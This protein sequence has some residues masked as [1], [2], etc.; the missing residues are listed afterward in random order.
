MK[1]RRVLLLSLM[2]FALM[3]SLV[4]QNQIANP[5]FEDWTNGVPDDWSVDNLVNAAEE[6]TIVYAGS[7]SLGW[8]S[9]GT[10][11]RTMISA[12]WTPAEATSCDYFA[13]V[14]VPSAAGDQGAANMQ[15]YLFG[16]SGSNS[17][18]TD[19]ND[20]VADE[21]TKVGRDEIN[22]NAESTTLRIRSRGADATMYVDYAFLGA[23]GTAIEDW[24]LY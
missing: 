15:T 17:G 8:N 21:W 14:Y 9:T 6:T 11:N 4:G 1:T 5:Y 20:F 16:G 3:F 10:V 24:N 12:A 18:Y 13:Y 23:S 7:K 19:L 22:V 2:V